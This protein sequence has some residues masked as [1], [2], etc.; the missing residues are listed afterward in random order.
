VIAARDFRLKGMT[1]LGWPVRSSSVDRQGW[2]RAVAMFDS[3]EYELCSTHVFD[4]MEQELAPRESEMTRVACVVLD[5]ASRSVVRVLNAAS[6]GDGGPEVVEHVPMSVPSLARG[7]PD[8]PDSD[9][10]VFTEQPR[11]YVSIVRVDAEIFD[12]LI[13]PAGKVGAD[14]FAGQR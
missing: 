14:Q 11:T 8:L 7:Q 3:R 2:V 4:V 13:S 10:S 1:E 12:Q 9:T 6:R 5:G